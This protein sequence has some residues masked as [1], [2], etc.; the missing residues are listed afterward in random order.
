M[1]STVAGWNG[2]LRSAA[3]RGVTPLD[4]ALDCTEF[5][6]AAT[7]RAPTRFVHPNTVRRVWPLARLR[8]FSPT[9]PDGTVPTLVLPPLS[10]HASTLFDLTVD[11]SLVRTACDAGLR[12]VHC[13]EWLPPSSATSAAGIDDVVAVLTEAIEELGGIANLVAY[14]QSGWLA[15]GYAA[16]HPRRVNTLTIAAAP[17]DFGPGIPDLTPVRSGRPGVAPA[18]ATTVPP[19]ATRTAA[20]R[21][22]EWPEEWARLMDLWAHIRDPVRV[23][24][25]VAV[26]SWLDA[27]QGIPSG[28]Y[29]WAAVHLFLRNELVRSELE[30]DGS[31][32]D[33]GA[34]TCPLFLLAGTRDPIVS[35]RQLWALADHVSTPRNL[36]TRRV[37]ATGHLGMV[38]DPEVLRRHWLPVLR[39]VADLSEP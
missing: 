23:A 17:I 3:R 15:A 7:R 6:Q 36:I 4:V 29:R 31:T 32:V 35:A 28:F 33:L 19:A 10:G 11:L 37:V 22:A 27:P 38:V 9:V 30:I 25:Y 24:A 2:Y 39:D 16:V 13:L 21:L 1:T 26:Q 14:S 18:G 8:E 5:L 12:G 20:L 34:V